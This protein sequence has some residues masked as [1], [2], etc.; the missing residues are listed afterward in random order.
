MAQSGRL[1]DQ[2]GGRYRTGPQLFCVFILWRLGQTFNTINVTTCFVKTFCRSPVTVRFDGNNFLVAAPPSSPWD[3]LRSHCRRSHFST[4]RP[5]FYGPFCSALALCLLALAGCVDREPQQRAAF[6]LFLQSRV[7]AAPGALVRPPSEPER[8]ALGSYTRQ[9]AVIGDFQAALKDSMAD[10]DAAVRTLTLR[11]LAEVAARGP[12]FQ[13]LLGR[14]A[15]SR[16]ALLR[17]RVH[18]DEAR[19]ALLQADDLKAAYA[20]AYQKAVTEPASALLALYPVI[21]DTLA[22]AQRVAAYARAHAEQLLVDGALAQ[23]RD[24]SVQSQFN[25]LLAQLNGRSGDVDAASRQ[26]GAL[27]PPAP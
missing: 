26:L 19:A 21:E 11:S 7:T 20:P 8:E 25:T 2:G 6:I 27:R 4:M 18:A 15:A 3:K 23:V 13:A 12:Q 24:P 1:A 9:Y 22:D 17:A 5:L 16:Q 10:I 14:L